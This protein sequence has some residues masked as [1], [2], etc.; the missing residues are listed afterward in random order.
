MVRGDTATFVRNGIEQ[1][2]YFRYLN[3]EGHAVVE[4]C[5]TGNEYI[6]AEKE[7]WPVE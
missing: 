4:D 3:E 6:V 2:V 1:K 5:I 7:L